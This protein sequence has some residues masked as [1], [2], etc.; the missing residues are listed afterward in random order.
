ME[1]VAKEK[2]SM[3]FC[4]NSIAVTQHEQLLSDFWTF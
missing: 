4:M 2:A 3:M 1:P